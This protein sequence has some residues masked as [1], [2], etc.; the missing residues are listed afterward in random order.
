MHNI[1]NINLAMMIAH[2][3]DILVASMIAQAM[4]EGRKI[5]LED[6]NPLADLLKAMRE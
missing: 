6:K 5:I 1:S 3:S 2:N 4:R